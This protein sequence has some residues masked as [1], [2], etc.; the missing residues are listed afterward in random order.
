MATLQR[1]GGKEGGQQGAQE[2]GAEDAGGGKR[3]PQW[4]GR[5][6]DEGDPLWRRRRVSV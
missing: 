5:D 4:A 6:H 3:G 2:G 1:R